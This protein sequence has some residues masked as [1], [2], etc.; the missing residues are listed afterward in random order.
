L[1]TTFFGTK[2]FIVSTMILFDLF[3]FSSKDN[4]IDSIKQNLSMN[5][6]QGTIKFE[7]VT[8]CYP[9]RPDVHVLRG[10]EFEAAAGETVAL[11]GASGCGIL[12]K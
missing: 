5:N 4:E 7:N 1:E 6:Y 3:T 10:L 2:N 12:I 11:V 8:F 9:S